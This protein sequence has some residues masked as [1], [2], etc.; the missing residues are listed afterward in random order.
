MWTRMG[1][2][3]RDVGQGGKVGGVLQPADRLKTIHSFSILNTGTGK[4]ETTK[5]LAKAI[6]MQV[7]TLLWSLMQISKFSH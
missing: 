3:D 5:D 1:S 4:T 2:K 6:A 7:C